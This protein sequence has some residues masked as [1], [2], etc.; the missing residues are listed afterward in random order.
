MPRSSRVA[1]STGIY[2]VLLRGIN[3]QRLFEDES[4]YRFFLNKLA[5]FRQ[6]GSF[7]L[8]AYCLLSNHVHLLVRERLDSLS[9]LF[10]RMGT[11]YAYYF[12]KKY[13]RSGHLFQDRYKSEPVQDD[14]YLVNVIRYIHQNPVLAGICDDA[15]SYQWSSLYALGG[16]DSIIDE[17][18]LF[19]LVSGNDI[20]SLAQASAAEPFKTGTRGRRSR[21]TEA[22]AVSLMEG[23][24]GTKTTSQFHRLT[25]AQQIEAVCQL[26]EQGISIRQVARICGLSKGLV[27]RW[28]AEGNRT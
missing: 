26:R 5:E 27:E 1:S 20:R 17:E 8:F 23:I 7:E 22:E 12:N 11:S 21:H 25:K 24:S 4:D 18:E 2:H 13:A 28:A 10:K 15:F 14:A 16:A 6:Q 3:Q 9:L 19:L